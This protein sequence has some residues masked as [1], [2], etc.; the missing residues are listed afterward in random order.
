MNSPEPSP[1][2]TVLVVEDEG[3]I[4]ENLRYAL[5]DLGYE[6]AATCYTYAEAEAAIHTA[7]PT[8][9]VLLDIN[10]G[11]LDPAHTGLALAAQLHTL[12][13]PF[14]FLTAYGDLDTI[15]QATRLQPH[16]YLIKPVNNA[17]L[18]AAIQTAIERFAMQQPAP[19]P[20]ATPPEPPLYFFVKVGTANHK[21]FWTDVACLEAGKNYVTLRTADQRLGY[22]V[23]GSL[24][25]VL[26]ALVP[27]TL[28]GQFLRINRRT[29]LNTRF[30][31]AFDNEW[32]YC[33]SERF[34][35]KSDPTTL[36]AAMRL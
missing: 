8:D 5:E 18:F 17:T 12:G 2:I 23:R 26:D 9:L 31:T 6:V 4:A 13:R 25:S 36:T 19:P 32:V 24:A 20:T 10:L 1:K 29:C 28:R 35:N 30:I 3:L 27:P 34:E 16:G 11:S 21:L 14:I 33:G 22:P 7:A 15:R